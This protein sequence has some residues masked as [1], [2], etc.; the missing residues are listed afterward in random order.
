MAII[1]NSYVSHYQRVYPIKSHET[2]IFLWFS[3][4]FSMVFHRI[5]AIEPIQA[6]QQR[7][8]WHYDVNVG[9]NG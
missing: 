1:F 7:W 3:H 9:A 6:D 2:T 5:I 4:V 8:P